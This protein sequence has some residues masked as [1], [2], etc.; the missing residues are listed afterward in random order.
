MVAILHGLATALGEARLALLLLPVTDAADERLVRDAVVDGFVLVGMTAGSPVVDQVLGRRLPVVTSG[1]LRLSGAPN[2]GVDDVPA[3]GPS[4]T[5][6][7]A[8]SPA[9]RPGDVSTVAVVLAAGGAPP[10]AVRLSPPDDAA[11]TRQ[12]GLRRRVQGFWPGSAPPGGRRSRSS[13][14]PPTT[15]RGSP[16]AA[17]LLGPRP[18]R[19]P[20]AVFCVTDILALGVLEEA[21]DPGWAYPATSP[22]RVSTGRRGRALRPAADDRPAGPLRSGRDRSRLLLS[23]VAGRPTRSVRRPTELVVGGS[24]GPAPRPPRSL[25]GAPAG[26][27]GAE[28]T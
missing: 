11:A 5:T 9:L 15:G 3:A 10:E 23:A 13:G 6:C 24:T 19:R 25:T 8:G 16:A 7:R 12:G 2:V 22:L 17:T 21:A 27:G 18:G 26:S 4:P 20:T 14:S 1:S 28:P